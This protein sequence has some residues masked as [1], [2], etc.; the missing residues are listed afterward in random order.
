MDKKT[1]LTLQRGVDEARQIFEK[2]RSVQTL[3][4]YLF[5]QNAACEFVK[6]FDWAEKVPKILNESQSLLFEYKYI[7]GYF[8]DVL[9][10]KKYSDILYSAQISLQKFTANKQKE[11]KQNDP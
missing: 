2:D 11:V 9:G 4:N 7:L 1:L 8:K 10:I 6:A 3:R 5:V